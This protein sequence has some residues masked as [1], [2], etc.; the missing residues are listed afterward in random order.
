MKN[1]LYFK[2]SSDWREW[3]R[4]NFDKENEVWLIFYKTEISIPTMK[5]GESVEEALCFGWIDSLIKKIDEEK[6]ARKFH[7]RKENSFWS[8]LNKK[9]VSK[10]I[11][12]KRMT[13]IGLLKI[14]AAK[15]NGMW[16]KPQPKPDFQTNISKEFLYALNKNKRAKKYFEE[17][18]PSHKKQYNIWI[19]SAKKKETQLK[20]I[21]VAVELLGNEKKLGLK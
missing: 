18:A 10:L 21:K 4:Q 9:R 19:N 2:N 16:N 12:E 15:K 1:K 17:L 3:L 14:Q 11:K 7:P 6:Y 13:K 20:R 8:E 5:Y